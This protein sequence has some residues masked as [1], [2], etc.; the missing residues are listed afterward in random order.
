MLLSHSRITGLSDEQ[1]VA[2]REAFDR[3]GDRW[4]LYIV[5]RL[6]DGP[7]RFNELKRSVEGVSQRMLTLTLRSLERDG[8][9]TRT[10][11]PTNPPQVEYALTQSGRAFLETI[12]V[13]VN[14]ADEHRGAIET[15]REEFDSRAAPTRA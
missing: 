3:V 12:W 4:S 5:A 15:A 11:Y 13:L 1:C 9:I 8:L 14:W 6:R 7:V 2:A 10:V